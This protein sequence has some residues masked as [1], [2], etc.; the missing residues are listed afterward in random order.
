MNDESKTKLSKRHII[1][2]ILGVVA[3]FSYILICWSLAYFLTPHLYDWLNKHPHPFVK[4]LIN[5]VLGFFFFGLTII[6]HW[7]INRT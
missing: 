7:Q 2:G 6:D 3:V 4:Q 1:R 5:S